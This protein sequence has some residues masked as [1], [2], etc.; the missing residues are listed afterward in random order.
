MRNMILLGSV[1]M[2]LL[3][4]CGTTPT[5]PVED[6]GLKNY[7]WIGFSLKVPA[8][9]EQVDVDKVSA[10]IRWKFEFAMRSLVQERGF[11]N[12]ITILSDDLMTDVSS[13]EY[14]RQSISLASRE[15]LSVKIESEE[16]MKFADGSTSQLG[17]FHA[18]YN[19]V[20]EEHL[21][22]QTA[23]VCGKTVY[24]LTIGLNNETMETLFDQYK[25]VLA[26][27]TCST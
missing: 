25:N 24:L 13:W 6:K 8:S 5:A 23:K 10:P 1:L 15:Y 7:S 22:L 11:M 2:L 18:K 17:I 21:F 9:W 16:V 27:F 12:N 20:T 19:E 3:S 14:A 26:C 4:S